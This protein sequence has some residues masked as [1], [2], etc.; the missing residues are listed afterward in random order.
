MMELTLGL[1]VWFKL[2]QVIIGFVAAGETGLKVG[3]F[4]PVPNCT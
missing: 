1:L 2:N 4:C 3:L